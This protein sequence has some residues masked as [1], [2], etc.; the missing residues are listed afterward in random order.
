MA[1]PA[2]TAGSWV[3]FTAAFNWTPPDR[4]GSQ[5]AYPAG[6]QRRVTRA[7]ASAAVAAGK[8]VRVRAPVDREA[9][10]AAERGDIVLEAR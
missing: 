9:A 10:L 1:G 5:V 7:C 6:M 4:P 8:A 3:R 2:V